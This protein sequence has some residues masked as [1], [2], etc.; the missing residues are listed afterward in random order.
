IASSR[1]HPSRRA[2]RALLRVG[3]GVGRSSRGAD[4]F[5]LFFA[6]LALDQGRQGGHGIR[7]LAAR[8]EKL[9]LAADAGGQHHQAHDGEARDFLALEGNPHHGV[10]LAGGA[11]ELGGGP[12]VQAALVGDGEGAPQRAD[13]RVRGPF[14]R[15]IRHEAS[16]ARMRE[17]TVMYLRPA[18]WAMRTASAIGRVRTEA[19]F[20]SIGRLTPA[21]TSMR[22]C[23]MIE[24]AR[25]DGVPPNMSVSTITPSPV[26]QALALSR[27]SARRFSMSSSAP[28]QTANTHCC[29][30]TTCS[31]A[32]M[33]SRARLPWVTSTMPI[34]RML[35]PAP[36]ASPAASAPRCERVTERP[37]PRNHSASSSATATE[38]CR[39]PVQP[40]AMVK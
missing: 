5:L 16:L 26:S 18:S 24:I 19:S 2:L 17:A 34:I 25:L 37:A 23:S 39:P 10:E 7:R 14:G 13:A 28:I 27:I 22:A 20:T 32:A 38:R 8:A 35:Y 29:G 40:M 11:H 31:R 36:S 9:D 33:N 15:G 4:R 30:P 1:R 6:E 21:S 3:L 12:G